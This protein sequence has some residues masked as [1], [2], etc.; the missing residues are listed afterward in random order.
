MKQV[1][2]NFSTGSAD[3]V[4]FRPDSP[5]EVFDFIYDHVNS[6][7]TA[8]DCGTGNGQVACKL[9]EK[10][11]RVYGTDISNEQIQL[12]KKKDNITYLQERAEQTS[13][14]DNSMD[15]IKIAQAIHWFD[16]EKFY[17]EVKRVAKPGALIATWTYSTLKLTP[18]VN[19]VID[20]LYDPITGPY[21]DKERKLVDTGYSTIPFPFKEIPVPEFQIIRHWDMVQV[22]GYLRTWSGVKHYVKKEGHDP[23][24][25]VLDDLKKAWG[26]EPF[27]Q[28]RWP[29]HMR[30]GLVE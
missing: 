4:T 17:H 22:L 6:F 23:T 26:S 30:A 15:L 16:F 19:E 21:W 24:L 20:Q 27:L 18:E 13:L 28:V 11:K 7:D 9:A 3:Y 12:A 14:P 8:W 5:A 1:V 2:D 25:L 29:V 10:F